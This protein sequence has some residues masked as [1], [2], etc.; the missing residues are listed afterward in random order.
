MMDLSELRT[1]DNIAQDIE[2]TRVIPAPGGDRTLVAGAEMPPMPSPNAT[3]MGVTVACPVCRSNNPG[4][5]TY[6]IQGGFLLTSV[7]G[8]VE[9]DESEP[10]GASIELVESATGRTFRLKERW[11]LVGRECRDTLLTDGT[12]SGRH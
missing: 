1:E 2:S 11:L 9:Q 3:Q 12:A 10:S 4:L 5:E 6:C 7:P 8:S